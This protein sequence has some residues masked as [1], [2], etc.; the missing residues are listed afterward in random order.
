MEGQSEILYEKRPE[1]VYVPPYTNP[2]EGKRKPFIKLQR[3]DR[4]K[5]NR[6]QAKARKRNRRP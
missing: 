5:R 6:L 1:P 4:K 2:R 3:V